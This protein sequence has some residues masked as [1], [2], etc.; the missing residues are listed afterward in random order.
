MP[1]TIAKTATP[2]T[3]PPAIAPAFVFGGGTGVG[4]R[5]VVVGVDVE[6]GVGDDVGDVEVVLCCPSPAGV[7]VP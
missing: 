2:P 1:T 6:G 7:W 3:T 4:V 5:V